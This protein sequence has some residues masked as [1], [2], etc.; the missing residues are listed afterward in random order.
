M[1]FKHQEPDH[2]RVMIAVFLA[3]LLLFAWQA[4]VDAPRKQKLAEYHRAK[5]QEQIAKR[6]EQAK[7]FIEKP[8]TAEENPN[9]SR[10]QRLAL[11][12]RLEIKSDKLHGSIALKGARFDHLTLAKYRTELD[13]NSPEV[14][15]FAPN[16]DEKTFFTQ[17]GWVAGD[18]ATKVP[19]HHSLWQ[20]DN[21]I[22][23]PEQPVTLSWNNGSG[24][25]FKLRIALDADYMFTINQSVEN[26]G[27]AAANVVPYAFINRIYPRPKN[28]YGVLHEG[29]M[30]VMD[31]TLTEVSYDELRDKGSKVFDN[32]SGWIGITDKYWLAALVPGQNNYKTT[33]SFY[34][35]AGFDRFQVDYLG[36]AANVA[37][38]DFAQQTV[39]LFAGAKEIKVLDRYTAGDAGAQMPP[40][41]LFDRAVDFG[42]LYF[43]T[44][45]LFLMLNFF[46]ALIGNF[47]IAIMLLTI[48]VKLLM[49]PLANKSY[50]SMAQMRALQ[51]EMVKIRERYADDSIAMNKEMMALYK[52]EKVN[53]AA[54]CLPI[55]IQMPVFFALYK[56]LY[57]TIEMRHA[58][59]FG[60][61]K[62]LSVT[63]PSNI[64]T[65]FGLLPWDHPAWL[66][67]GVLPILF[68]VTMIIQMK[69][70][71]KPTDPV[72]AKMMAIMPYFFLYL[73]AAFP[74]GLVLYWVWSNVLSILQQHVISKRYEARK[75][76]K[77]AA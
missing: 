35:K 12:P 46:Y 20:A 52:R 67:I 34:E 25:I 71:P 41:P 33:F 15:L 57:V 45:P 11:S 24:L 77:A 44:K 58:P 73:F 5:Q 1:K 38:G 50:H 55:L 76:R 7:Q 74:A 72:Q 18:G 27:A 42:T 56:V 36:T 48:V 63:D 17:V 10:E 43:L 21:K 16:G 66:H 61:L 53:P 62:D 3:A 70:Q 49:F 68:T 47:G 29:P 32:A 59:F 26:K 4:L 14:A 60:W 13:I 30:G 23:T 37:P 28:H 31:G 64:F 2:T 69:Q 51:P 39:R 8:T 6:E 65:L 54:G 40:I 75:A 19:D 22:L 9:L